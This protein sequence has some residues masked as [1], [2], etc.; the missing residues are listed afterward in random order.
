MG[1]DEVIRRIGFAEGWLRRAKGNYRMGQVVRGELNLSLAEAEIRHAWELSRALPREGLYPQGLRG[2]LAMAA[3]A[4]MLVLIT[5]FLG[6]GLVPA[7][8]GTSTGKTS[9]TSPPGRPVITFPQPV[10]DLLKEIDL[11]APAVEGEHTSG[12]VISQRSGPMVPTGTS[13]APGTSPHAVAPGRTAAPPAQA[14]LRSSSSP[15]PSQAAVPQQAGKQSIA[16]PG[17]SLSGTPVM[18]MEDLID[19]VLTA[20]RTLRGTP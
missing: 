12:K 8:P 3:L 20:E 10:G 14:R 17:P 19:L 18:A 13:Q 9:L 11:P 6:S 2:F 7:L 16:L 4:G 15:T 1:V 5:A